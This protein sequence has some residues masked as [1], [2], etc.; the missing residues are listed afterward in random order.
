MPASVLPKPPISSLYETDFY[1]W[2]LRT[3]ALLREG[4]FAELDLENTAEEIEAL[5][6]SDY[7]QLRNRTAILI[8][9]LLK[10]G[11]QPAKA[12]RSWERTIAQQRVRIET[13]LDASPSLRRTLPE[14]AKRAWEPGAKLAMADTG[15]QRDAFPAACPFTL[16]EIYGAD[17]LA[18]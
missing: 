6:R 2:A 14:I 13:V 11:S 3:A 7:N 8:A 17:L 9:H 10:K 1:E 12:T 5:A 18:L 15:L 4:R 16:E